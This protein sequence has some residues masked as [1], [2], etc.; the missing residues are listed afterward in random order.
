MT[1]FAFRLA[2]VFLALA[3]AAMLAPAPAAAAPKIVGTVGAPLMVE[4]GKGQLVHLDH[5]VN[6]VFVADPDVADVQ[7][8]SPTLVYVFGKSGGETTLYAVGDNDRVVLNLAVQ[9][10]YDVARM[11]Q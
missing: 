6:T 4:V 3:P 5:P 2:A 9:V 8:K 7:V 10:R 11:Q 1:R